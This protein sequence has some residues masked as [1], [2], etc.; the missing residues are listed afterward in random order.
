MILCKYINECG[1]NHLPP[2]GVPGVVLTLI[3]HFQTLSSAAC[4]AMSVTAK[5]NASDL[6]NDVKDVSM[7]ELLT[8]MQ[9]LVS[10]G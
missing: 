5:E 3:A 8:K 1:I 6:A 7:K 10:V 9:D 4:D 2:C